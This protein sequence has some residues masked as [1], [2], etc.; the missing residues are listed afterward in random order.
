MARTGG[1]RLLT[2]VGDLLFS[3][4]DDRI[5]F[6]SDDSGAITELIIRQGGKA[7]RVK[8]KQ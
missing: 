3:I 4:D 6:V 7:F 1:G 2:Q 5:E 8:R